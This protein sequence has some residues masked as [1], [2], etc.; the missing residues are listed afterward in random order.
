M[1]THN[2]IEREIPDDSTYCQIIF[3][4]YC[5]YQIIFHQQ[6]ATNKKMFLEFSSACASV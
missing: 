1:N 4:L 3:H 5:S 2:T 6:I